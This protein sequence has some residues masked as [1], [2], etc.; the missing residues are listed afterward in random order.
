MFVLFSCLR[1][2]T[3]H[4]TPPGDSA[5]FHKQ[6]ERPILRGRDADA[7]SEQV[8]LGE[9]RA[10]ELVDTC[11]Q[12]MLRRTNALLKKYLPPKTEQVV[13]CRLSPLQLKLYAHFKASDAVQRVL[14]DKSGPQET[15]TP[16]AVLPAITALKKLC[17]HPDLIYQLVCGAAA[18]PATRVSGRASAGGRYSGTGARESKERTTVTGFEGCAG[19]FGE[20]DVSPAY[21][22]YTC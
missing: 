8:V 10:S 3:R 18:A 7:T 6:Y 11:N 5:A 15:S 2:T 16:L 13:F 4:Q 1:H 17:A 21:I 12:F 22:P 19:V 9:Q 14:R 20:G